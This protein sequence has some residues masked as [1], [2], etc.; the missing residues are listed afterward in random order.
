M[1]VVVVP[2]GD[3]AEEAGPT[4]K[5]LIKGRIKVTDRLGKRLIDK[6]NQACPQRRHR[7]RAA[8]DKVAAVDSYLITGNGVGIGGDVGQSP[9]DVM[10][11]ISRGWDMSAAL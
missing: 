7:A 6:R 11:D 3:V 10:P 5:L 8:D 9:P 4:G 1:G 2:G